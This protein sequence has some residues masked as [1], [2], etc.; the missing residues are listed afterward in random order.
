MIP[1]D[2]S[3]VAQHLAAGLH[4]IEGVEGVDRRVLF[5]GILALLEH[6]RF[7]VAIHE[8]NYDRL[9]TLSAGVQS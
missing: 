8:S 9:P 6:L 3:D 4:N 1:L 5:L 2:N 7:E